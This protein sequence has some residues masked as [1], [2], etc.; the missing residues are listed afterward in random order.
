M[1][2]WFTITDKRD[3]QTYIQAKADAIKG[4]SAWLYIPPLYRDNVSTLQAGD[5]VFGVVDD[6]SGYGAIL[7]KKD[8]GITTNNTLKVN[9]NLQLGGDATIAG[10]MQAAGVKGKSA[11]TTI[12]LTAAHCADIVAGAEGTGAAL[13]AVPVIL[14][15]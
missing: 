7:Y 15:N 10:T 5:S 12:T 6:A 3:G 8:D 11:N 2:G 9:N 13:T 14:D 1:I 4:V